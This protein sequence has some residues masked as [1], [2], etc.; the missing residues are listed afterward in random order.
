M[1]AGQKIAFEPALAKVLAEH[2]HD[3]AVDAEIDVD[4]STSAIHSFPETS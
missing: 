4:G 3:A 1:A 2:F